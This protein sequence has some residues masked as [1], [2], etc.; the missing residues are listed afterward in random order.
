MQTELPYSMKY[1]IIDFGDMCSSAYIF[2]LAT[3]VAYFMLENTVM[4]F[5]DAGRHIVDGY[6]SI[7]RLVPLE[8]EVLYLGVCV[9][10]CQHIVYGQMENDAQ[11]GGNG[12]TVRTNETGWFQLKELWKTPKEI[13]YNAW[14][15]SQH[16]AKRS[17]TEE[18]EFHVS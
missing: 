7:K 17:H 14:K 3:T 9:R 2:D 1:G 13:V 5:L 12:Y 18:S 10:Y 8:E 15:C 4:D 16:C 11:G 6:Q